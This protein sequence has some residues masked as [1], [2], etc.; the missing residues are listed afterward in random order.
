[1]PLHSPDS[2]FFVFLLH[3]YL[4]SCPLD[5]NFQNLVF[6]SCAP[7]IRVVLSELLSLTLFTGKP[8]PEWQT[9][10]DFIGHYSYSLIING[11]SNSWKRRTC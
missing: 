7:G 6:S 2:P 11:G 5:I 3:E 10:L 9:M 1:M 8:V 4:L